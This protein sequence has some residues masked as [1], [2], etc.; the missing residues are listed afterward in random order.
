MTCNANEQAAGD[1]FFNYDCDFKRP[2]T[3]S[4]VNK[5]KE[6]PVRSWPISIVKGPD[7]PFGN[8]A[9]SDM[10]YM[11]HSHEA[12]DALNLDVLADNRQRIETLF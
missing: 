12:K 7:L 3:N 2:S 4:F 11:M 1:Q 8:G 10:W 9:M 5:F 6:H